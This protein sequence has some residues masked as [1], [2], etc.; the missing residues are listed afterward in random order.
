MAQK[1]AI[2]KRTAASKICFVRE[3]RIILDHDLALLYGVSVKRLNEQVK[4]NKNRFPEDFLF[5]LTQ[6]EFENLRSQFA[7]SSSSHGGRRYTPYAFTEHGAVMVATILNSQR[8]VEMSVFVVR[9]LVRLR[10]MLSRHQEIAARFSELELRLD[11][12]D[13]SIQSIVNAIK[14]LMQPP[15]RAVRR[16]GFRDAQEGQGKRKHALQRPIRLERKSQGP[17]ERPRRIG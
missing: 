5:H 9:A 6:E 17:G 4:R 12:H 3:K 11:S 15:A 13:E 8:A 16:I 7:T 14:S 2:V 10:E 1:F